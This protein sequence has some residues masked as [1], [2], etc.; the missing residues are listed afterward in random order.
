[1]A[2]PVRPNG[3]RVTAISASPARR[4]AVGSVKSASRI[5]SLLQQRARLVVEQRSGGGQRHAGRRAMQQHGVEVGLEL[6]DRPAQRGLADVQ[7]GRR[8]AE[9]TLLS[10]GHEVPQ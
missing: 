10:D 3:V 1:V 9:V 8:A 4:P 5:R 7:P 2:I 6:L